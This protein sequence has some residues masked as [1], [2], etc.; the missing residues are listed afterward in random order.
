MEVET[1]LSSAYSAMAVF[2]PSAWKTT[3]VVKKGKIKKFWEKL[4]DQRFFRSLLLSRLLSQLKNT[5]ID[6]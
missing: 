1:K 4:P 2:F 3:N 6:P 5:S